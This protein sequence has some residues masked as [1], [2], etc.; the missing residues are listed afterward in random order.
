MTVCA[1]AEPMEVVVVEAVMEVVVVEAVM[2]VVVMEVMVEV[3]VE[4]MGAGLGMQSGWCGR[5]WREAVEVVVGG[6]ACTSAPRLWRIAPTASRLL[7]SCLR[8]S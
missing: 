1:P 7:A 8:T 4:V 5:W 3:M 2:E 6:P